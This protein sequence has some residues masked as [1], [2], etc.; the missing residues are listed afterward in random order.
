MISFQQS[1]IYSLRCIAAAL[2]IGLSTSHGFEQSNYALFELVE[3]DATA[4]TADD[5]LPVNSAIFEVSERRASETAQTPGG[6]STFD[7][8]LTQG[9]PGSESGGF[10]APLNRFGN[11]TPQSKEA[12][13]FDLGV[14]ESDR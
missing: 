6:E 1:K 10:E 11:E 9:R 13:R 5:R 8:D 7:F 14:F 3:D 2:L 12:E 4:V